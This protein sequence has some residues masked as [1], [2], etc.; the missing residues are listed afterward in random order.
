MELGQEEGQWRGGAVPTALGMGGDQER[1]EL[2]NGVGGQ[3][4]AI[5]GV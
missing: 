1:C 2:Q 5:Q 3:G 4:K